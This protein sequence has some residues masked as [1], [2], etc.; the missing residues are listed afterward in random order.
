MELG[1]AVAR[2]VETFL[3]QQSGPAARDS[4]GK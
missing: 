1:G 3:V 4:I 2:P